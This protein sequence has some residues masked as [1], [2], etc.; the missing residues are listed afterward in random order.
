MI[1]EECQQ[2][3]DALVDSALKMA[4]RQPVRSVPEDSRVK[5]FLHVDADNVEHHIHGSCARKLCVDRP[6]VFQWEVVWG[7]GEIRSDGRQL[8][9]RWPP[10]YRNHA[11][12]IA[13]FTRR[14]NA[15]MRK[16]L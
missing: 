2:P 6:R 5:I 8:V 13:A 11:V 10:A 14:R 3:V 1:L 16:L 4:P 15:G 7:S 9:I 12:K